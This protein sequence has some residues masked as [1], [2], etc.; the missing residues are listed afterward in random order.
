MEKTDTSGVTH[1][2]THV[3]ALTRMKFL[4][5]AADVL[6]LMREE[7]LLFEAAAT[8]ANHQLEGEMW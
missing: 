6:S 3:Y 8:S 2:Y 1:T 7:M 4:R 5:T